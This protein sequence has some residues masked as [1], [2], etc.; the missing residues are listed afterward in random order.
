MIDSTW[1]NSGLSSLSKTEID[2]TLRAERGH[3]PSQDLSFDVF[4]AMRTRPEMIICPHDM[5]SS[6]ESR[7]ENVVLPQLPILITG[8]I[9]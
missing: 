3:K 2:R 9:V 7:S 5:V 4:R 6:Y 8:G 1:E